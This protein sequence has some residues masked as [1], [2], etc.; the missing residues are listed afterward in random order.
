MPCWS[1]RGNVST[2]ILLG[3]RV[4]DQPRQVGD[5]LAAAAEQ[6]LSYGK[7]LNQEAIVTQDVRYLLFDVESVADGELIAKTRYAPSALSPEAA[8]ARFRQELLSSSGRDFIPYTF[9]VP[10]AVVVAKI[11]ADFQ[12]IEI[13]SL[14]QPQH[15]PHVITQ[16]FWAGW[17]FYQHPTWVTFNGRTFDLPLMEHAAFRFAVA[18]PKWFNL[19]GRSYEQHRNRYNLESH[20]DLQE[21][22]SNYGSTWYRGGLN[23][24]ATLLGK[25]GKMNVQGDMVYDLYRQGRV[26]DISE[27]C[28]C[29]VLDTYFVFLRILLLM[30]KL[31]L[32]DEQL[33]VQETRQL[34]ESQASEHPAYQQYLEQWGD[35]Q[36]PWSAPEEA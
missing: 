17:E 29:D 9:H 34:L 8:V 32:E 7:T 2:T 6:K 23:L 30:G 27:Y 3:R 20:F 28:R 19:M 31:T 24:A 21:V 16:Q 35:W 26:D 10:V 11:R 33:R 4:T 22:L 5:S 12:L 18:A 36:N 25:P 13:V 14:D 1:L 15:R